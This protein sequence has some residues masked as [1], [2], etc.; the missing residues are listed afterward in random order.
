VEIY[1]CSSSK[2]DTST[3]GDIALGYTRF[4]AI[5][6]PHPSPHI[7]ILVDYWYMVW[8]TLFVLDIRVGYLVVYSL[9]LARILELC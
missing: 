3:W 4:Y 9:I 1:Y 6:R 2:R 7:Q 5:I 8:Y